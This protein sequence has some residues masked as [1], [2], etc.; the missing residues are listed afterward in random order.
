V[1]ASAYQ[2]KIGE[3]G[4]SEI[5]RR[6]GGSMSVAASSNEIAAA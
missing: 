4:I 2:K 3:G 1:K 6:N 5:K